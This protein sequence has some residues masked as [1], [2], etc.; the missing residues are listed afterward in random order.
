M[1]RNDIKLFLKD[2]KAVVLLL[3]V[4]FAFISLF[5]YA[6]KPYLNKTKFLEPFTIAVVDYEGT[7][8]T[9]MLISQLR[10]IEIFKDILK[11]NEDEAMA[12][13]SQNKIASA[14]II[15]QGFTTSIMEGKNKPVKV[16][17]NRSMPFRSY[18][19]KSLAESAANLVTAG[20]SAIN[21][22]FHYSKRAGLEGK[23]LEEVYKKST[24]K[25]FLEVL[26]RNEMFTE[27][28]A[29]ST[30]DLTPTEYYTASLIVVFLMFAGMPGLKML[31]T[32]KSLG[33]VDRL[34]TSAVKI[35]QVVLSK[36]IVSL[37]LS[38]IQFS[39]IV[40]LTSLVLKNYWGSSISNVLILLGSV[41]F[42]VSAWSVFVSAVSK[43]PAAADAIGNMGILLMAIIGGSIY[44]LQYLPETV[45]KISC[46]TINK[47]ATEGFMVIFS[48]NSALGIANN[49]AALMVIGTGFL[50]ISAGILK[51]RRR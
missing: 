20:Q 7:Q 46:L 30:Y 48:G 9:D 26:S 40:A 41:I 3:V 6:L 22:V 31:V 34:R 29:S 11:V 28:E 18:V 10:D 50:I 38:I 23:D 45:R 15:P 47:W 27:V 33:L 16:I 35:W 21:T 32:E 5:S 1:L 51:L 36:F 39:I 49:V 12:L 17:G 14:I 2:W 19:V 43:T 42:A 13:V 24:I 4:P 44:P 8:Q 25:F 37:F